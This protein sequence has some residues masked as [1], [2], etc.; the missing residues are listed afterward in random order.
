MSPPAGPATPATATAP[1]RHAPTLPPAEPDAAPTR[2]G[3]PDESMAARPWWGLDGYAPQIPRPGDLVFTLG[4]DDGPRSVDAALR[5]RATSATFWH[6]AE[7]TPREVGAMAGEMFA[8]GIAVTYSERKLAPMFVFPI[9]VPLAEERTTA[10]DLRATLGFGAFVAPA[11]P[12]RPSAAGDARA[13][14]VDGPEDSN[15][16]L[17]LAPIVTLSPGDPV[18]V[19]LVDRGVFGTDATFPTLRGRW[20]GRLPLVLSAPRARAECR[21]VPRAFVDGELALALGAVDET[22]LRLDTT[23]TGGFDTHLPSTELA[24]RIR[25][26]AALV[27][28]SDPRV[29]R[30]LE[31]A[32]LLA[33]RVLDEI[34]ADVERIARELPPPGAFVDV[35]PGAF[36]LRIEG[37][38]CGD[39]A[40]A[41][42]ADRQTWG[43]TPTCVLRATVENRA[44]AE[45]DLVV[46][47]GDVITRGAGSVGP[48]SVRIALRD[49]F[50]RS[51][52]W[53][54]LAPRDARPSW[55]YAHLSPGQQA[56]IV[57]ALDAE[58]ELVEPW[59][60]KDPPPFGGDVAAV[61]PIVLVASHAPDR[62]A[63]A[64][65]NRLRPE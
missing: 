51:L 60:G 15:T 18:S 32:A 56:P 35:A 43:R 38:A 12:R 64:V 34:R 47:R 41:A 6:A 14:V 27:G 61:R 7:T 44:G 31:R 19:Q 2:L 25:Y 10:A 57:M 54:G 17:L 26:A 11:E 22:L 62:Y 59:F 42:I 39:A 8:C 36:A 33:R 49:R 5:A 4:A 16:M 40:R 58:S 63:R 23:T 28:W 53:A 48:F 65:V 45:V 52:A 9:P 46:G 50:G 29:R 37:F 3:T 20:E 30:R 24:A 13:I 55:L 21:R 1:P